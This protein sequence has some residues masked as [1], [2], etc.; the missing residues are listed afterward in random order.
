MFVLFWCI[1]SYRIYF[2]YREKNHVSCGQVAAPFHHRKKGYAEKALQW[3]N[4]QT[5]THRAPGLLLRGCSVVRW[6]GQQKKML[7][8]HSLS[9]TALVQLSTHTEER[10]AR[11]KY[12]QINTYIHTFMLCLQSSWVLLGAASTDTAAPAGE[13]PAH[14]PVPPPLSLSHTPSVPKA[15][16]VVVERVSTTEQSLQDGQRT[17]FCA[18]SK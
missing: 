5:H 2:P 6:T 7:L 1:I 13:Q 8:S 15:A 9:P 16:A 10:S 17:P 11:H 14:R 4:V 3:R 12:I 18:M